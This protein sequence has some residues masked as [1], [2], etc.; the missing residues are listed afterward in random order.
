M[1][2][3]VIFAWLFVGQRYEQSVREGRTGNKTKTGVRPTPRLGTVKPSFAA[4][5]AAA[6]STEQ[7]PDATAAKEDKIGDDIIRLPH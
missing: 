1:G 5:R 2:G 7:T 4:F 6:S 3:P